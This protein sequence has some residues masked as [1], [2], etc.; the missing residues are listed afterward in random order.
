M[1]V[2]DLAEARKTDR[3][4]LMILFNGG[5]S[6]V[7]PRKEN[8]GTDAPLSTWAGVSTDEEGRVTALSLPENQIGGGAG[9]IPPE[10]GNLDRLEIL[11]LS[12]NSFFRR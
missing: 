12:R 2:Y 5:R 7:W 9:G 8:W 3:E 4:V 1:T 11:D 6:H 10:L